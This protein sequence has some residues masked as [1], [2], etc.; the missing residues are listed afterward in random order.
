MRAKLLRQLDH[1]GWDRTG[2]AT[3]PDALCVGE[4][5]TLE[6]RWSP[7]G[8]KA[9]LTF[10]QHAW[11]D[12]HEGVCA[13]G[14]LP[15]STW[16]WGLARVPPYGLRRADFE[17]LFVALAGWRDQHARQASPRHPSGGR[18]HAPVG[19][20]VLAHGRRRRPAAAPLRGKLSERKWRLFACACLRRLPLVMEQAPNVRAVEAMERYADGLCPKR[21]MKKARKA[22]RIPWLDS[23]E[24]ADEAEQ[25]AGA[26][27]R[28]TPPGRHAWLCE[29]L[30]DLA[31]NPF[32]PTAV[33]PSWLHRNDGAVAHL[34][35]FIYEER[36][37]EDLPILADALEDAGCANPDLL[38]HCRSGGD[39]APGCWALDVLLGK[40]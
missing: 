22:A 31:G 33:R 27:R 24:P 1:R 18:R 26:F 11:Y 30:R 32:R 9:Y 14:E 8:L 10:R 29:L 2:V 4:A 40:T 16:D 12:D 35:R 39:H 25:A 38:S 19:R 34:A 15:A 5:W 6:S 17:P 21:D 13:H 37:F 3:L 7:V 23:Y 28:A 36:H 20:A